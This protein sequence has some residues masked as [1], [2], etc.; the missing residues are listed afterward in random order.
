MTRLEQDLGCGPGNLT[1]FLRDAW[2]KAHIVG[3][4]T[5][6]AMLSAAVEVAEK[7]G[8]TNVEFQQVGDTCLS[9]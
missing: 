3:V 1:R 8:L 4:D 2:P 6:D 9:L 5:S 7:E